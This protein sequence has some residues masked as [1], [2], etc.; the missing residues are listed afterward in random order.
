[1]ITENDKKEIIHNLYQ[2]DIIQ[3]ESIAM[4]F[5]NKGRLSFHVPKTNNLPSNVNEVF[6]TLIFDIKCGEYKFEDE[7]KKEIEEKA[8]KNVKFEIQSY[9]QFEFS[10]Q[11]SGKDDKGIEYLSGWHL[12]YEPKTKYPFLKEP[13]IYHPL[14]HLHYGGSSVRDVYRELN[15]H[16]DF[17]DDKSCTNDLIDDIKALFDDDETKGKIDDI[18]LSHVTKSSEFIKNAVTQNKK[19]YVP[20]YMIAPRIPFP[21]MDEFLG[22]DFIISNFYEKSTYDK[23]RKNT[24][25]HHKISES[26]SNLWKNYYEIISGYWNGKNSY[27]KPNML[28]PSLKK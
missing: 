25:F 9:S 22:L 26:Q 1:M 10:I 17:L 14:F 23:F 15:M 11:F 19:S 5:F 7:I 2:C 24:F 4:S 3:N 8:P 6:V 12:D 20:L 18:F 27:I 28:N 16:Q 21:P 13:K